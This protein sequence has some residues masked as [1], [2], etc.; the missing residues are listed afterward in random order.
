M[1]DE[2]TLGGVPLSA[3]RAEPDRSGDRPAD[4]SLPGPAPDERPDRSGART[5]EG[6][7]LAD[8][9][10][11]ERGRERRTLSAVVDHDPG[12]LSA[13]AGL[14]SRR[15]FNIESLTVGPT[16]DD[17]YARMT[18][19]VD[20]S[21]P[22]VEQA[23]KQLAGLESVHT[24]RGLADQPIERELALVKVDCTAP[25]EVEAL[26]TMHD[27]EVV[28]VSP[29]AATVQ[30]TGTEREIDDA[31]AAFGRFGVREVSRTGTT[32]LG[33][34]A[35]TVFDDADHGAAPTDFDPDGTTDHTGTRDETDTRDVETA[36][37]ARE[38][39]R[40]TGDA[41]DGPPPTPA[42]EE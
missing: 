22:G 8:A 33:R 36:T 4:G 16:A 5:D 14:F 21:G 42:D 26:A 41:P 15:M 27:A 31:V 20:E 40:V 25:G 38:P 12:V 11:T 23:R 7:R 13:V 17:A 2:E 39:K 30:V 9:A 24:V 1:T 29:T 10:A 3:T 19:V 37:E 32:A 18:I 6:V 35:E 28:S 34:G